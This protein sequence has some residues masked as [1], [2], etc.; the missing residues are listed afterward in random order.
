MVKE[1]GGSSYNHITNINNPV[2]ARA[3][4]EFRRGTPG[5]VKVLQGVSFSSS[6]LSCLQRSTSSVVAVFAE[7]E[8]VRYAF[9]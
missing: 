6:P 1:R 9:E 7:D 4:R 3:E 8:V 5:K 2:P